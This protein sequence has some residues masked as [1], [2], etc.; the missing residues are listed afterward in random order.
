MQWKRYATEGIAVAVVASGFRLN[1][2]EIA[3]IAVTAALT[4]AVLDE[5]APAIGGSVRQGAGFGFGARMAGI[6]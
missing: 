2:A 3:S 1:G 4:L 5:F 6:R